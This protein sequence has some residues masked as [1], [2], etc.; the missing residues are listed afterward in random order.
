MDDFLPKLHF[1]DGGTLP[2]VPRLFKKAAV[3]VFEVKW[4]L[5][6]ANQEKLKVQL[7]SLLSAFTQLRDRYQKIQQIDFRNS[8]V[9]AAS[10]LQL[11]EKLVLA[12]S[13]RQT[14]LPLLEELL[15]LLSSA[16][17]VF[18]LFSF[19]EVRLCPL[20]PFRFKFSFDNHKII[21]F[22]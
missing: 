1:E 2:P 16:S 19:P 7:A 4:A 5:L 10:Q 3:G 13:T 20:V 11:I 22:S 21:F 6:E 18:I 17:D 8:L 9:L 15:R 12:Q 14:I